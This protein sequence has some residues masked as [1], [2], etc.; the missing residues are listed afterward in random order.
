MLAILELGVPFCNEPRLHQAK[1][2]ENR[3]TREAATGNRSSMRIASGEDWIFVTFVIFCVDLRIF[4][5]F[6]EMP[7]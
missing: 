7:F 1:D 6:C 3:S 4:A 2:P 5:S